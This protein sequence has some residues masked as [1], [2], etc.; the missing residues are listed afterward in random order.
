[1][2]LS[3]TQ[4]S[5]EPSPTHSYIE[6]KEVGSGK[7]ADKGNKSKSIFNNIIN[8]I[9]GTPRVVQTTKKIG[10]KINTTSEDEISEE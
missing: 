8:I 5:V 9:R 6:T 3:L 2:Y 1:M 4:A 10:L 7:K